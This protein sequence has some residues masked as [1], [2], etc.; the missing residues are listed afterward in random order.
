MRHLVERFSIRT[1][2]FASVQVPLIALV[3]LAGSELWD[4]YTTYTK[5]RSAQFAQSLASA[6]GE[7]AQALPAEALGP[8]EARPEARKRTDAAIASIVATYQDARANRIEDLIIAKDAELITQSKA[9]LTRFRSIVDH[10]GSFA[11]DEVQSSGLALQP[12]A[13][14][15]ID[16]MRRAGALVTDLELS[17]FIQGYHALLQINDAGLIEHSSGMQFLGT[18][19]IP[20]KQQMLAVH[21]RSL[22][23][24]YTNPMLE[25]LPP[26]L[27]KPYSD[28][29]ASD[30]NAFMQP[31]RDLI[32]ASLIY[33]KPDPALAGRWS[34]I[35]MKRAALIN[36]A[37]GKV[38]NQLRDLSSARLQQSWNTVLMLLCVTGSIVLITVLLSTAC[39]GGVARPLRKIVARMSSLAEGDTLSAVPYED[40]RDE[41]G[42]IAHALSHFRQ[43]EI[44]KDRM[45]Q[46]VE[47]TRVDN[48]RRRLED[49][50]RAEAEADRRLAE[51]ASSLA[52]ALRRLADGDMLCEINESVDPKFEALR[53]D[54]NTSVRQLR[55]AL[56]AVEALA[57]EVDNG[58]IEISSASTDLSKRTEQQ[59]ASLEETAAALE[60]ITSNVG[61]TSK[62]T[63]DARRVVHRAR[64]RAE[65][66]SEVVADA[67]EAME[68]I[69]ASSRQ[70][71]QIIAVIDEIAFQT[72]LL[73]LNAGVE[74]A[75]AGE[76]GKGF[77]VVAQEVRELAQRSAGAAKEI[78][79]LIANSA[80]AVNEGVK[81]V[82]D[83]G[84]GLTE[85]DQLVRVINE[86]MD[87][88]AVAAQEQSA[89]LAEIN[90]AVNHLDQA[91]QKNA[92][93]VEEMNAAGVGLANES[94]RLRGLLAGFKIGGANSPL[95]KVASRLRA[96]ANI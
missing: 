89:G 66:S 6:G 65:K 35:S 12:V 76:A 68:R 52:G 84:E 58:S 88:I 17:R 24:T 8:S 73:A 31:F 45:R 85:I 64:T 93:M 29:V 60:E 91:T 30:D 51:T 90:H 79:L 22:F 54:F 25:F 67:V 87:A 78:K 49:H 43:T 26:E 36:E 95:Q 81:L 41:I 47:V 69:E 20:A 75:R 82:N 62:R 42:E 70:I 37:L 55:D 40:R 3:L 77:A 10:P 15:G 32:Y 48:E 16:L 61:A 46:E 96:G 33:D 57:I 72:N 71:N 34:K 53:H 5:L 56:A 19:N 80:N 74:A 92:A 2:L 39:I 18:G 11:P 7:L 28:F 83:T 23:G 86:H 59:A 4:T 94:N 9:V 63:E 13:A 50:T 44:D 1:L 14:A 27:T 38:S 21:S